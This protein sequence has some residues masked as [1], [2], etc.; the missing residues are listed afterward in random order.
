MLA[1]LQMLYLSKQFLLQLHI[2]LNFV[3]KNLGWYS[4][5]YWYVICYVL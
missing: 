1:Y 4:E 2:F 3:Y 5:N